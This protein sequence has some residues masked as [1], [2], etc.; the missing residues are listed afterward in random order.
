[1]T[2]SKNV[3][4]FEFNPFLNLKSLS[5]YKSFIIALFIVMFNYSEKKKKACCALFSRNP[6]V[7]KTVLFISLQWL[8]NL[9]DPFS[10]EKLVLWVLKVIG[11]L[12]DKNKWQYPKKCF[13]VWIFSL[14][15]SSWYKSF[16]VPLFKSHVNYS[17]KK[18]KVVVLCFLTTHKYLKILLLVSLQLLINLDDPFFTWNF[19]AMSS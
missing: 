3:L 2:I 17:E 5:R 4:L 15:S 9:D 1:M 16:I 14:K 18:K 12:F 6:Q 19:F 13:F 10:P 7:L 8:I 11:K